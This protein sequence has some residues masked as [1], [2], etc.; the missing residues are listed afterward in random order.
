MPLSSHHLTCQHQCTCYHQRADTRLFEHHPSMFMPRTTTTT[1]T[2][3]PTEDLPPLK[4]I[5]EMPSIW[6]PPDRRDDLLRT[7]WWSL[8]ACIYLCVRVWLKIF[9]SMIKLNSYERDID[10]ERAL[11][12]DLRDRIHREG[13]VLFFVTGMKSTEWRVLLLHN[14]NEQSRRGWEK[15]VRETSWNSFLQDFLVW[16]KDTCR[17]AS[18]MTENDA[19][20]ARTLSEGFEFVF[21]RST[22]DWSTFVYLKSLLWRHRLVRFFENPIT[23][24]RSVQTTSSKQCPTSTEC[25]FVQRCQ[26]LSV[27]LSP[28]PLVVCVQAKERKTVQL[29]EDAEM[30]LILQIEEI[31]LSE[32][33]IT[34]KT[35]RWARRRWSIESLMKVFSRCRASDEQLVET[36][37]AMTKALQP[38][39][40]TEIMLVLCSNRKSNR[41]RSWVLRTRIIGMLVTIQTRYTT[42]Q[43]K[44]EV[45]RRKDSFHVSSSCSIDIK[46]LRQ[47]I[48]NL[49]FQ[50]YPALV[51][52]NAPGRTGAAK[53]G[54][55]TLAI[56][57]VTSKWS[58]LNAAWPRIHS[59]SPPGKYWPGW[60]ERHD[61]QSN[62]TMA[63]IRC[64]VWIPRTIGLYARGSDS[65]CLCTGSNG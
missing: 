36:H 25:S 54:L 46:G 51:T 49:A 26:Y 11:I 23:V 18:E 27:W 64:L 52:L 34:T 7:L 33:R 45:S 42:C 62:E 63:G 53:F 21:K 47:Q 41:Y 8:F 6:T 59:R 60:C 24:S 3:H 44:N 56:G 30:A 17:M 9:L 39:G 43:Q 19:E 58:S 65:P 31:V 5:E 20:I 32:N 2:D 57:L 50:L 22:K 1:T 55:P 10:A 14:R 28:L 61:G 12:D 35:T 4:F 13:I 40:Q 29:D 16:R 48:Q 15:N 37:A 38:T